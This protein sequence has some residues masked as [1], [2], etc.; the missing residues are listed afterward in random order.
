MLVLEIVLFV[1]IVAIALTL[2]YLCTPGI[3]RA[4]SQFWGGAKQHEEQAR[5]ANDN[6]ID[7]PQ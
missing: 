4:V 2:A 1:I 7:E 3:I 6:D 5:H